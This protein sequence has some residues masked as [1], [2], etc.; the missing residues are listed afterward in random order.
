MKG[1]HAAV[2]AAVIVGS[3]LL[4]PAPAHADIICRT[5]PGSGYSY[6]YCH[7][8]DSWGNR[9]DTVTI[10]YDGTNRCTTKNAGG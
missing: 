7:G 5:D 9:Y 10:C 8:T 6:T 3:A 2:S 1:F 4:N